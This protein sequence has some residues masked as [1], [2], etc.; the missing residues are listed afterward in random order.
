MPVGEIAVE[1]LGGALRFVGSIFTEVIFEICVKGLGYV[2]C[3]SFSRSVSPD[4]ILVVVVG[5]AAWIFILIFIVLYFSYEYISSQIEIDRCLD[6]GG[7]YNYKV[8][9]CNQTSA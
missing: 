3:R 6:V 2:I 4:G 5:F 8:N 1:V 9:Q 7:S